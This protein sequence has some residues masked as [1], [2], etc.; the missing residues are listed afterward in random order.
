MKKLTFLFTLALLM[1]GVTGVK[2]EVTGSWSD[3]RDATWGTD[4]ESASTFTIV[5]TSATKP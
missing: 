4:Y 2:A 3:Y 5:A 1:A